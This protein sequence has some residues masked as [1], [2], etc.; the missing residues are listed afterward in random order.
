MSRI[1]SHAPLRGRGVDVS[2]RALLRAGLGSLLAGIPAGCGDGSPSSPTTPAPGSLRDLAAAKGILYGAGHKGRQLG[3]AAFNQAFS[4]ECGILVP[5]VDLKWAA[6]RPAPEG[7]DFSNAD[8]LADFAASN[9]I[10]LRGHTLIWHQALPPWLSDFNQ[11]DAERLLTEHIEMVAGRYAGRMHSWDVV[12]EAIALEDGLPDG[13][14]LTP[15]YSHLGPDYLPLAFRTAAAADPSAL[16]VYNDFGLAYHDAGSLGKR[17]AVLGLLRSLLDSGAPI[18]ALGIQ[19]HLRGERTDFDATSLGMF[20]RNVADLGLRVMVTELDVRD[21]ELPADV[22][23]RD[24]IVASVYS[25]FLEAVLAEPA[26]IAVLT[27]GLSD[28]YTSLSRAAPRSDR[29][30]VRVLPL[31]SALQPKLAWEA[32]AAAFEAAPLRVGVAF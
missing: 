6:L 32:V 8:A 11:A 22:R 20:I 14:R 2:R 7:F 9:G 31:D 26:V 18:H 17:E 28:R 15:W 12:N 25:Q 19:A 21:N 4:R 3:D 30:P 1:G 23:T 5:E 27:W 24:R 10:Q 13:L 16:L 29:L